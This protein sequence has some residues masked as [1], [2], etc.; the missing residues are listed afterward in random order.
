MKARVAGSY[1]PDCQ[2]RNRSECLEGRT[3]IE[4][5]WAA[6]WA[7]EHDYCLIKELWAHDADRIAGCFIYEWPGGAG[8]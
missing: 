1:T 5:F 6:K 2:W 4:A 7:R 3:A 8:R